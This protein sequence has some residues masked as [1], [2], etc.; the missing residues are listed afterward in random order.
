MPQR[1]PGPQISE[2]V[3]WGGES[4]PRGGGGDIVTCV[5]CSG[6]M[7]L[8]FLTPQSSLANLAYHSDWPLDGPHQFEPPTR[9]LPPPPPPLNPCCSPLSALVLRPRSVCLCCSSPC[10]SALLGAPFAHPLLSHRPPQTF[11]D[12]TSPYDAD[13]PARGWLVTALLP[14]AWHLPACGAQP[15][16]LWSS[17]APRRGGGGLVC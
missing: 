1:A 8:P 7:F 17:Q 15:P 3:F 13:C 12:F 14:V 4:V 11:A 10:L 9:L 5:R 2:Y 16:P 6:K